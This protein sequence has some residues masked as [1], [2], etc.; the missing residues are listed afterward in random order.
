M[1]EELAYK[2]LCSRPAFRNLD[3]LLCHSARY[4]PDVAE[5]FGRATLDKVNRLECHVQMGRMVPE[6]NDPVFRQLIH[7]PFPINY[8]CHT[9]AGE[10]PDELSTAFIGAPKEVPKEVLLGLIKIPV[11]IAALQEALRT[12]GSPATPVELNKRFEE[13]LS[14]LS[15]GE[16]VRKARIV[17]E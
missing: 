5:R 10:L 11:T 1:G 6:R 7:S 17:L 4:N 13:F 14:Q 16:D 8:C 2:I 9:H 12:G 3:S 15:K